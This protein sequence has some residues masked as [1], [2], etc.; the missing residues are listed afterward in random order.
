M[1]VR[2]NRRNRG[3]NH[4][5]TPEEIAAR[6]RRN[7]WIAV[8][9]VVLGSIALGSLLWWQAHRYDDYGRDLGCV[10]SEARGQDDHDCD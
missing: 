6:R 5:V 1:N 4:R 10:F 7:T 3:H 9:I 8:A 2:T